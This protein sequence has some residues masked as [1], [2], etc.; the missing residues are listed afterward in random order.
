MGKHL[1]KCGNKRIGGA[2][3]LSS[4]TGNVFN[5]QL[6]NQVKGEIVHLLVNCKHYYIIADLI[7][8]CG[9]LC[10]TYQK[11]FNP[12]RD[13]KDEEMANAGI[14]I[15]NFVDLEPNKQRT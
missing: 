6:A 3:Y 10:V 8:I 9:K 12:N 15:I 5:I 13:H 7:G 1:A 14:Q 2:L 11:T 4:T